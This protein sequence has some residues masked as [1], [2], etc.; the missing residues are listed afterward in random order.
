MG[1]LVTG[2]T[3]F[4]GKFLI[5]KLLQRDGDI[6]VLVR[7]GSVHKLEQLQKLLGEKGNRLKALV[8]DIPSRT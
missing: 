5:K 7:Q 6:H 1:Y 3:G 8:G 4:I 2:G